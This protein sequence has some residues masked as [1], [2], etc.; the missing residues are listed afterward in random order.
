MNHNTIVDVGSLYRTSYKAHMTGVAFCQQSQETREHIREKLAAERATQVRQSIP[1]RLA[2]AA[3]KGSIEVVL[4]EMKEPRFTS[5]YLPSWEQAT[6]REFFQFQALV[7][8]Y[9]QD[10]LRQDTSV[11][12]V[13]RNS[14]F[15]SALVV[16]LNISE[17]DRGDIRR[18]VN[19]EAPEEPSTEQL[20]AWLVGAGGHLGRE[21]L[22]RD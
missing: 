2:Q 8:D 21:A 7:A 12:L 14:P 11:K 1:Q 4:V 10:A 18:E 3:S 6:D 5:P 19:A 20:E 22:I 15:G 16:Q 13:R 17:T 9:V